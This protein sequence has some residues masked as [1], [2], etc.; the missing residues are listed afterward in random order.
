MKHLKFQDNIDADS[1]YSTSK[2]TDDDGEV[3]EFIDKMANDETKKWYKNVSFP[4]YFIYLN[5]FWLYFV[6]MNIL[7]SQL[8]EEPLD[9]KPLSE[10]E[11][12]TLKKEAN[13]VLHGDSLAYETSE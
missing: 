12:M 7:L 6:L 13:S 5:I 8:P 11:V 10:E 9:I 2:R 1:S 3:Q 4:I